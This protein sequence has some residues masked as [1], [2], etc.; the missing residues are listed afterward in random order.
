L[1]FPPLSRQA[2]HQA[3]LA[4]NSA[5]SVLENLTGLTATAWRKTP[6]DSAPPPAPYQEFAGFPLIHRHI[7]LRLGATTVSDADLWYPPHNLPPSMVTTL[8]TTDIPFGH[9]VRPLNPRREM[10]VVKLG[11]NGDPY[12]L[13]HHVAIHA[14][15]GPI[16]LV[17][18]RYRWQSVTLP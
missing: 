15:S 2:L 17:I 16:A 12:A 10:L 3:L 8:K 1:S 4:S 9:I 11:A 7:E 6:D 18:E 5:T 14:D 13:E